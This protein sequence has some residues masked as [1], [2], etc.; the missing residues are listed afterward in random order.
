M[1][2]L[3]MLWK[4][5]VKHLKRS[6][7]FV[8]LSVHLEM[9][10]THGFIS[11]QPRQVRIR[12]FITKLTAVTPET[13]IAQ[14]KHQIHQLYTSYLSTIPSSHHRHCHRDHDYCSS[15]LVAIPRK[16]NT[17]NTPPACLEKWLD[18]AVDFEPETLHR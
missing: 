9:Q 16:K 6:F 1:D 2:G 10:Q 7:P 14:S 4:H 11:L 15:G 18:E 13:L 12:K 17:G 3:N 5:G 8:P